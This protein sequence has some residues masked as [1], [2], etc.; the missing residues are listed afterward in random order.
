MLSAASV[1]GVPWESLPDTISTSFPR[2]RWYRAKMSA[3]TIAP[4]I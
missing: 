1:T 2:I 3:G 4:E